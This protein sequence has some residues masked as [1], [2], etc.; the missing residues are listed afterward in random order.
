MTVIKE[1]MAS[2]EKEHLTKLSEQEIK[3]KDNPTLT[4]NSGQNG[5]QAVS[6]EYKWVV[7]T[8]IFKPEDEL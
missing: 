2:A 1:M 3:E 7:L 6:V 8:P 4:F 5:D